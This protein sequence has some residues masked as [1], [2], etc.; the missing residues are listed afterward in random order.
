MT[1]VSYVTEFDELR[2]GGGGG[3]GGGGGGGDG[4]DGGGGDGGGFFRV[5]F[6]SDSIDSFIF[7][8][9]NIEQTCAVKIVR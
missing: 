5:S 7:S 1:P 8:L 4:G 2:S 6:R 3:D 9:A